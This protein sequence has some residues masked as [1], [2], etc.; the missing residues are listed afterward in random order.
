MWK[1]TNDHPRCADSIVDCHL[2]TT[3]EDSASTTCHVH[4]GRHHAMKNDASRDVVMFCLAN[5]VPEKLIAV[6]VID[7][8]AKTS[9]LE[10]LIKVLNAA[11]HEG[12]GVHM[13]HNGWSTGITGPF[14]DDLPAGTCSDSG[15][16][17]LLG[18]GRA[19]GR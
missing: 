9:E 11:R 2:E 3:L 12:P 18:R 10:N 17:Q 6:C 1:G 5:Q 14:I 8:P 19:C 13:A 15:P 4:D 7:G 16:H